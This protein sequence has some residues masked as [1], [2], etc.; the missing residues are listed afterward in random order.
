MDADVR[1]LRSTDETAALERTARRLIAAWAGSTGLVAP[2]PSELIARC[3][4]M[5]HE[6][7]DAGDDEPTALRMFELGVHEYQDALT[8]VTQ[9]CSLNQRPA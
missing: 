5:Y 6:A 8:V 4:A 2:T 3:G 7:R 9:S 1:D